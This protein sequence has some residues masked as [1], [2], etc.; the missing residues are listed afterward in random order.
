MK[1]EVV[2]AKLKPEW[3]LFCQLYA[4]DRDCFGNGL[5]AYAKTY[6]IDLSKKGGVGTAKSNAYKLLTNTD[7]LDRVNE[8]LDIY[9]N[10][11]VVDKELGF[12]VLQNVDFSA[13]LGAIKEYNNLKK[14]TSAGININNGIAVILGKYGLD[15]VGQTP[16]S[17]SGLPEDTSRS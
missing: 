15:D 6:G 8:L 7:I 14:R 1:S 16:T 5:Q 9:I 13:K 4:T 17:E 3:E 12:L 2:R 10:D 11:Q